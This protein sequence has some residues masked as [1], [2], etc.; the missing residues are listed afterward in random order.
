MRI[1]ILLVLL[2]LTLSAQQDIRISPEGPTGFYQP[3]DAQMQAG[4]RIGSR[5][6]IVWGSSRQDATTGEIRNILRVQLLADTSHVGG[7]WTLTSDSAAPSSIVTVTA[8]RDRFL[9]FWNDRRVG[10]PG[11]YM[12]VIDTNGLVLTPEIR[13]AD[14]SA[15]NVVPPTIS[16]VGTPNDG[17]L[18]VWYRPADST[19][20]RTLQARRVDA[21]GAIDGDAINLGTAPYLSAILE[22]PGLPGTTIL[23][24]LNAPSRLVRN[25]RLDPRPI[26]TSHFG[27]RQRPHLNSDTSIAVVDSAGV[28]FYASIFDSIPVRRVV[29][30]SMTPYYSHISRDTLG[31]YQLIYPKSSGDGNTLTLTIERVLFDGMNPL[32][33]EVLDRK[34]FVVERAPGADSSAVVINSYYWDHYCNHTSRLV[35]FVEFQRDTKSITTWR[36]E[37]INYTVESDGRFAPGFFPGQITC[38]LP[39]TLTVARFGVDSLSKVGFV[40]DGIPLTLEH[41]L[42]KVKLRVAETLPNTF[43]RDGRLHINW[44]N[45]SRALMRIYDGSLAA[46]SQMV[47]QFDAIGTPLNLPGIEALLLVR[48]DSTASEPS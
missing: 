29:I 17:Y 20:G 12:Q 18:I 40:L 23:R 33:P 25:G 19:S 24:M 43:E 5:A 38:P 7:Q 36:N 42:E 45:G 14:R 30:P 27:F 37:T 3:A 1:L 6:L 21:T 47:S 10:R 46:G 48:R 16:A 26:P 9:V 13:F 41:V 4:A 15:G 31:R 22:Y 2:S 39:T 44:Q 32:P 34:T 11:I 28:G 35:V 8:L